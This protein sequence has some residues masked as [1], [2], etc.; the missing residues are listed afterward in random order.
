MRHLG[1]PDQRREWHVSVSPAVGGGR[2]T[3]VESAACL[4]FAAALSGARQGGAGGLMDGLGGDSTPRSA[5]KKRTVQFCDE[6][7]NVLY[8]SEA[9]DPDDPL[10][11]ML[12]YI[13]E[14]EKCGMYKETIKA[15]D[16]VVYRRS[17]K[18]AVVKIDDTEAIQKLI[19]QAYG[20]AEDIISDKTLPRSRD[21][22]CDPNSGGCGNEEA[23]FFQARGLSED[24]SMKLFFV[25][26]K[27]G[28]GHQWT[29]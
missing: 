15:E 10:K 20:A 25:C 19:F 29:Y 26:T 13:C 24:D 28:C 9:D 1:L 18:K 12:A 14:N 2:R 8:P 3:G 17:M 22:L 7:N 5:A 21:V 4:S 11:K 6:C 27:P 16:S 23:C